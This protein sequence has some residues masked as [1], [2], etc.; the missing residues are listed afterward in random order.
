MKPPLQAARME[1]LAPHENRVTVTGALVT[2]RIEV[3]PADSPDIIGRAVSE[4]LRHALG[5]SERRSAHTEVS[6]ALTVTFYDL[7][8]IV[9]MADRLQSGA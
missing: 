4:A 7:P 1:V 8:P 9:T 3:R 6:G 2:P 5:A